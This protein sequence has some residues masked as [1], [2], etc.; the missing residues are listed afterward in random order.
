MNN[1]PGTSMYVCCLPKAYT[2]RDDGIVDA[3]IFVY[4]DGGQPIGFME[5]VCWEASCK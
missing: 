3:D 5:E 2:E 4:V 1:L